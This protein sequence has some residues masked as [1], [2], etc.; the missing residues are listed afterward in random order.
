MSEDKLFGNIPQCENNGVIKVYVLIIVVRGC[1][2]SSLTVREENRM[3]V[4]RECLGDYLD[5]SV[6]K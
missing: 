6:T 3:T 2:I 1:E 4:R 5:P